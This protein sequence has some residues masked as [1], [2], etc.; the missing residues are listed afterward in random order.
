MMLIMAVIIVGLIITA[1]ASYCS[2]KASYI[3]FFKLK[4]HKETEVET[5]GN[6]PTVIYLVNERVGI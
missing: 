3:N 1:H 5:L 6:L 4:I 2:L